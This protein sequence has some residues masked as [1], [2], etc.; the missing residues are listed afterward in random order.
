MPIGIASAAIRDTTGIHFQVRGFIVL[1]SFGFTG[2]G[3]VAE[4]EVAG[5]DFEGGGAFVQLFADSIHPPGSVGEIV[6]EVNI[7]QPKFRL[8]LAGPASPLALAH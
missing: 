7:R 2:A 1:S 6:P 8:S 4:L 5:F 3:V